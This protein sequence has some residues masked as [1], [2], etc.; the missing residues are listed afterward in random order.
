MSRW[1]GET[2][3]TY[4]EVF[5][6][7]PAHA[8]YGGKPGQLSDAQTAQYY[9][10][11]FLVVKEFFRKEELDPAR[12]AINQLVDE[13]AQKLFEAGKIKD[14]YESEGYFTRLIKIEEDFP[15]ANIILHKTEKL[16]QAFRNLWSNERL[17]NVVEQFVGPDIGGH[18]VWNLRT[19]TPN[20]EATTVPWH[21]DS[22]YMAKDSYGKHILTAW[23]PLV[24]ANEVNGC[25]QMLRAGHKLGKVARHQCCVGPTWYVETTKEEMERSLGVNVEEDIVTCPI[26][27]GG[28]LLFN[29]ITPH[30][31]LQN[32]SNGVRWS[33][34]LRWY[35]PYQGEGFWGLKKGVVMRLKDKPGLKIDWEPFEAENRNALQATTISS[36]K[37]DEFDTTVPGPW[38][39]QWEIV[40]H[41]RH[42]A[43]MMMEQSAV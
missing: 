41:N 33:M 5:S 12:E 43:A 27:Y 8:K 21:Q 17:L 42:T 13:L 16:P 3:L 35:N 28:M 30:R 11:G 10:E 39:K 32:S 25:M 15:G 18:P 40:N 22:A 29:N 4:P 24:D 20:N 14:L 36:E 19:K 1:P 6:C 34:D 23:I 38:M 2:D 9:K 31:S 37:L 7:I 26:P